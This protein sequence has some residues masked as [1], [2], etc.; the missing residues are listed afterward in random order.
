MKIK[1]LFKKYDENS[2]LLANLDITKTDKTKS[3]I[4]GYLLSLLI[5][6]LPIVITAHFFI[7]SFYYEL[8]VL[9]ITLI[10]VGFLT[11]G[12]IFHHNL[13]L[14]FSGNESVSLKVTYLLDTIMYLFMCMISY[15]VIILLF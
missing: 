1:E 14:Y 15:I 13:L 6:L 11:L 9:I 7:Y 5:V 3:F 10:I 12:E 8:V 4:F 2:N